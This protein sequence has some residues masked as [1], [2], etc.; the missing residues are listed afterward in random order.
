MGLSTVGSLVEGLGDFAEHAAQLISRAGNACN[1]SIQL[2]FV[3]LRIFLS[4]ILS[5]CGG[6]F[7]STAIPVD[8]SCLLIDFN[9]CYTFQGLQ[10]S[11]NLM[12]VRIASNMTP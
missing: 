2:R 8:L 1:W 12:A 10:S 5:L 6:V 7:P 3:E 9:N 4:H 11:W